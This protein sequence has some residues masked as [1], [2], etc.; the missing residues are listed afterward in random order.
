MTIMVGASVLL[1]IVAAFGGLW[2][3]LRGSDALDRVLALDFLSITGVCGAIL[4]FNTLGTFAALDV[5]LLLAMVGFITALYFCR[6]YHLTR[7]S[8]AKE[9]E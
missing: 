3:L 2:R 6:S 4:Y 9:E 5:A 8:G 7:P 1:I